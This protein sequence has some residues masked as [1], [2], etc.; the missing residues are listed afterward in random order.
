MFRGGDKNNDK[1]HFNAIIV[2]SIM[3][4]LQGFFNAFIY[5]YK[6]LKNHDIIGR[7]TSFLSRRGSMEVMVRASVAVIA[8]VDELS[9]VE[10]ES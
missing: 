2:T 4:P 8:N 9:S 10:D 1:Y 7:S 5:N 6:K 3:V